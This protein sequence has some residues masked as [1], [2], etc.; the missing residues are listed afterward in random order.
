MANKQLHNLGRNVGISAYESFLRQLP[1]DLPDSVKI[2]EWRWQQLMLSG[3]SSRITIPGFLAYSS[4]SRVGRWENIR[5]GDRYR[6]IVRCYGADFGYIPIISPLLPRNN[7]NQSLEHPPVRTSSQ[8]QTRGTPFL[9]PPTNADTRRTN[10]I[11]NPPDERVDNNTEAAR[12]SLEA[13][14]CIVDAY[15][16]DEH[17]NRSGFSK[18]GTETVSG[19]NNMIQGVRA[20]GYIAFIVAPKGGRQVN[21]SRAR[22]DEF[23]LRLVVKGLSMEAL[24]KATNSSG[25]EVITN[26]NGTTGI[27][28]MLA[29]INGATGSGA[30]IP[31]EWGMGYGQCILAAGTSSTRIT[32]TY[33]DGSKG[34]INDFGF[35]TIDTNFE[36]ADVVTLA[37]KASRTT[38]YGPSLKDGEP[39]YF[40]VEDPVT[41]GKIL[42]NLSRTNNTEL[43]K[44]LYP[45]P[46]YSALVSN[47]RVRV[48][49]WTNLTFGTGSNIEN[50]SPTESGTD[51]MRVMIQEN[52]TASETN[53]TSSTGNNR[54]ANTPAIPGEQADTEANQFIT[55]WRQGGCFNSFY[56]NVNSVALTRK[57]L[58][59]VIIGNDAAT[60]DTSYARNGDCTWNNDDSLYIIL[61]KVYGNHRGTIAR[62]QNI[63]REIGLLEDDLD[64]IELEISGATRKMFRTEGDIILGNTN[65]SPISELQNQRRRLTTPDCEVRIPT[66]IAN[67]AVTT[68]KIADKNVTPAKIQ[69]NQ[70]AVPTPQTDPRT[71]GDTILRTL[72]NDV[73]ANRSATW[74]KI[75]NDMIPDNT[76]TVS[77]LADLNL[78]DIPKNLRVAILSS[79]T[80]TLHRNFAKP[81]EDLNGIWVLTDTTTAVS[82]TIPSH[83]GGGT[84]RCRLRL[85]LGTVEIID[86]NQAAGATNRAI[87]SHAKISLVVDS[88]SGQSAGAPILFMP[89]NNYLTSLGITSSTTSFRFAAFVYDYRRFDRSGISVNGIQHVNTADETDGLSC[90]VSASGTLL[91]TA[92]TNVGNN[93]GMLVIGNL[94]IS[95]MRNGWIYPEGTFSWL[96]G[97]GD[98]QN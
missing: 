21:Q 3:I 67:N 54:L 63:E 34:Q 7:N 13:F 80:V 12:K 73:V 82:V 92:A 14:S 30:S 18:S 91:A 50:T 65:G 66:I 25:D 36:H 35:A 31:N 57:R 10:A 33:I 68:E 53:H 27:P 79:N 60:S 11:Q 75:T 44:G 37:N 45:D 52:G 71:P 22:F 85:E 94:D 16:C 51:S 98:I 40:S 49:R 39:R 61:K 46:A 1:P 62:I 4:G 64:D 78:P 24:W 26:S 84:C 17:G 69:P 58:A 74:G 23:P 9:N 56:P 5:S 29:N 88:R 81:N 95:Q 77:K 55:V 89:V 76:I 43:N 41:W 70:T 32:E 6:V 48:L 15:I 8:A 59:E 87:T 20:G 28:D 19:T 38:Y 83:L 72:H 97:I 47:M 86:D 2:P 96:Q 93:Q 90:I 42:R